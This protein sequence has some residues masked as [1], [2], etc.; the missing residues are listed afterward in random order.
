[1]VTISMSVL[2]PGAESA[3]GLVARY[4][5]M[6]QLLTDIWMLAACGCWLAGVSCSSVGRKLDS[7]V[8]VSVGWESALPP[9]SE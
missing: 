8:N 6:W 2:E 5:S 4:C 7:A 1:M 3:I 9:L